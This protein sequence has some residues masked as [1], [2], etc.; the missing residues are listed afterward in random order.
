MQARH[1]TR[2]CRERAEGQQRAPVVSPLS[3]PLSA[4]ATVSEATAS[5]SRSPGSSVEIDQHHHSHQGHDA[6]LQPNDSA[7][8]L[9]QPLHRP[10]PLRPQRFLSCRRPKRM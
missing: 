6:A 4:L 1:D 9:Q 10:Q 3:T 5:L 2:K 8:A 7:L